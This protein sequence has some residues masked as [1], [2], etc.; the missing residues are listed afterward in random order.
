MADHDASLSM[1]SFLELGICK[2]NFVMVQFAARLLS[3]SCCHNAGIHSV[4]IRTRI[5]MQICSHILTAPNLLLMCCNLL[6]CPCSSLLQQTACRASGAN[7]GQRVAALRSNNLA[8]QFRSKLALEAN[9]KQ[10]HQTMLLPR[11]LHLPMNSRF[12][13]RTSF[14]SNRISNCS[15]VPTCL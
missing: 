12:E 4:I 1:A 6:I 14:A 7:V 10:H 5:R 15:C 3:Y 11:Q 13:C 9:C 2:H 8:V